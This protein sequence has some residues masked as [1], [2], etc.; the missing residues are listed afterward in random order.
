METQR[1]KRKK[2]GEQ[3]RLEHLRAWDNIK[4]PNRYVIGIAG[5]KERENEAEKAYEEIIAKNFPKLMIDKTPTYP[6]NPQTE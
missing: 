3:N 5:G 4:Q 1:G 6:G 2:S